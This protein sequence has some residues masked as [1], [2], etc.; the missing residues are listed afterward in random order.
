MTLK[1]EVLVLGD[2]CL[3]LVFTGLPGMPELGKEIVAT[4]FEMLPGG[5]YNTAISLHRLGVNVGWAG[6]FGNDDFSHLVLAS[7]Q[8]EGLDTSLFTYHAKPLRRITV[9]ASYPEERAFIAY[10]DPD[11]PIPAAMK[12]LASTFARAVFIP[13]LY[14]GPGFSAGLKLIRMKCMA[15]IMDG[16]SQDGTLEETPIRKAIQAGDLFLPN[17]QEALRLTGTNDLE[18]ALNQLGDICPCVVVKDGCRGAW[19]ICEGEV[20]SA[21]AMS[22]RAVDTTGAGDAFNAGFI[23]AWLDN[24]SP[25]ECLHWGNVLGGLSTLGHGGTGR[26]ASQQE[27]LDCLAS[28]LD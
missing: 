13:G 24:K 23:K 26:V 6:D 3:D 22:L 15:L 7:V 20:M 8:R 9:S 28:Y 17:R 10:Y 14:W 21:P 5:T 1:F 27:I 12:A 11:P 19:A 2:Y 25:L 18:A 16:N 4:G